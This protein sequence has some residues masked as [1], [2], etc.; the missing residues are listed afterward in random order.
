MTIRSRR[1][2]GRKCLPG[3]K[4][5]G[6]RYPHHSF[7]SVRR[8]CAHPSFYSAVLCGLAGTGLDWGRRGKILEQDMKLICAQEDHVARTGKTLAESFI[9]LK[10]S[11][12]MVVELRK[13]LDHVGHGM[14]FFQGW[15]KSKVR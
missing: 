9:P 4:T 3:E 7:L 10:S 15:E 14:P 8:V 13:W 6:W 5:K 1:K 12:S 2:H 11:D